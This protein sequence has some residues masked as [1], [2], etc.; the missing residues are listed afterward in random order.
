MPLRLFFTGCLLAF[1]LSAFAQP[2]CL[3]DSTAIDT[4]VSGF[5]VNPLPFE[6]DQNPGGGFQDTAC[7]NTY[8][9]TVVQVAI[10][11]TASVGGT[12]IALDSL[13]L[14][15]IANLPD[16]LAYACN[17]PNCRTYPDSFICATIYG[18]PTDPMDIDSNVLLIRA[19]VYAS[20]F[21][22]NVTYPDPNLGA[23]GE[24]NL[25]VKST[26]DCTT[27]T[28]DLT[29]LISSLRTAPNP[30]NGLSELIFNAAQP[31]RYELTVTDVY[32]RTVERR[33]LT[34]TTGQNR[35]DLDGRD[36]QKGL[37]LYTLTQGTRRSSGR[38]IIQ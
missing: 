13:Q 34:A 1:G 8:F 6:A 5:G 17:P 27:G 33:S 31:G 18:I 32:G 28:R 23:D 3:P 9:E 2:I 7:I 21:P 19:T 26:A 11:D 12:S 24:Y 15:D 22:I 29:G 38:L 4:F 37:Y 10:G 16:G 35:F 36:W 25:V 30:S 14:T 20:G